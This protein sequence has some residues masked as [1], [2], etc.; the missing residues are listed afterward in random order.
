VKHLPRSDALASASTA[1]EI[2]NAPRLREVVSTKKISEVYTEEGYEDS[3]YDHGGFAKEAENQEGYDHHEGSKHKRK[4][5]KD[6]NVADDSESQGTQTQVKKVDTKGEQLKKQDSPHPPNTWTRHKVVRNETRLVFVENQAGNSVPTKLMASYSHTIQH[7]ETETVYTNKDPITKT[8]VPH[9]D[10]VK[11]TTNSWKPDQEVLPA[12]INPQVHK[13][14]N[15][16]SE[17]K[18]KQQQIIPFFL[19][20]TET[21]NDQDASLSSYTQ[22]REKLYGT[23]INNFYPFATDVNFKE[24]HAN[25]PVE[26]RD[27]MEHINDMAGEVSLNAPN[28]QRYKSSSASVKHTEPE[29]ENVGTGFVAQSTGGS[30]FIRAHIAPLDSIYQ[31]KHPTIPLEEIQNAQQKNVPANAD[32]IDITK[33]FEQD[34]ISTTPNRK[35]HSS[36]LQNGRYILQPLLQERN[37][38]FPSVA[39][40]LGSNKTKQAHRYTSK[41]KDISKLRTPYE[42]LQPATKVSSENSSSYREDEGS[43]DRK[44][45]ENS[46][47]GV[48]LFP[49]VDDPL[50]LWAKFI[51]ALTLAQHSKKDKSFQSPGQGVQL[52]GAATPT[53]SE[54]SFTHKPVLTKHTITGHIN[55]QG[56]DIDFDYHSPLLSRNKGKEGDSTSIT[57]SN[58]SQSELHHF[59]SASRNPT[60][61]HTSTRPTEVVGDLVAVQSLSSEAQTSNTSSLTDLNTGQSKHEYQQLAPDGS[62]NSESGQVSAARR[63]GN[64]GY[65]TPEYLSGDEEEI[66]LQQEEKLLDDEKDKELQKN[67]H[68]WKA[69]LKDA[70]KGIIRK[71]Q[72]NTKKYPFYKA[73]PSNTLS[74][75]SPLRYALNPRAIPSKTEGGMEFYESREHIHCPEVTGPQD[76]V[77][78]RTA[79]GEWN[80]KPKARLPRLRGLGD[81]IDCFRIKYFGFDPLDNPFFKEKTVGLPLVASSDTAESLVDADALGFYSDIMEHIRNIGDVSN[82]PLY[83]KPK[84]QYVKFKTTPEKPAKPSSEPETDSNGTGNLPSVSSAGQYNAE[85]ASSFNSD[86]NSVDSNDTPGYR[87]SIEN[88]VT[89]TPKSNKHSTDVYLSPAVYKHKNVTP[90]TFK[91]STDASTRKPH[92]QEE[93]SVPFP[94]VAQDPYSYA[95][96]E[97]GNYVP[98]AY[99]NIDTPPLQ[100]VILGMVPPP[101]PTPAYLII[102]AVTHTPTAH[103]T[104]ILSVLTESAVTSGPSKKPMRLYNYRNIQGLIP[105]SVQFQRKEPIHNVHNLENE[106]VTANTLSGGQNGEHSKYG[107]I[108]ENSNNLEADPNADIMVAEESS[109]PEI[110][111][112]FKDRAEKVI[113]TANRIHRRQRRTAEQFDRRHYDEIDNDD[114][115]TIEISRSQQQRLNKKRRKDG[116]K[117]K[118][119]SSSARK[120]PGRGRNSLDKPRRRVDHEDELEYQY[121]DDDV[122]YNKKGSK[123]RKA[124]HRKQDTE[125]SDD[126]MPQHSDYESTARYDVRRESDEAVSQTAS[127]PAIE[128][129]PRTTSGRKSQPKSKDRIAGSDSRRGE[130][131]YYDVEEKR[132][133]EGRT[134]SRNRSDTKRGGSVSK[135]NNHSS[136]K[137]GDSQRSARTKL[138]KEAEIKPENSTNT[139]FSCKD[140]EVEGG[141]EDYHS[142]PVRTPPDEYYDDDDDHDG[143]NDDHLSQAEDSVKE[144]E[145][146]RQKYSTKINSKG[147]KRAEEKDKGT[148]VTSGQT[149]KSDDAANKLKSKY[150]ENV[151]SADQI[152]RILGGFMSRHN[153]SYSSK[154][155]A[156]ET[157]MSPE[158][159]E[160]TDP[161]TGAPSTTT[162]TSSTSPT[163]NRTNPEVSKISHTSGG[164][165]SLQKAR[166]IPILNSKVIPELVTSTTKSSDNNTN[167]RRASKNKSTEKPQPS[168]KLPK[169]NRGKPLRSKQETRVEDNH[170][171]LD[172]ENA[173]KEEPPEYLPTRNVPST[174]RDKTNVSRRRN[175]GSRVNVRKQSPQSDV[176]TVTTDNTS[177]IRKRIPIKIKGTERDKQSV[178]KDTEITSKRWRLN[179]KGRENVLREVHSSS[180]S[181]QEENNNGTEPVTGNLSE[182]STTP[183]PRRLQA[184]EHRRVTKEEIF[185]TTYYPEDELAEE[186]ERESEIDAA[187][188][189]DADESQDKIIRDN[190]EEKDEEEDVYEPFESYNYE[191][192]HVKY[193]GNRLLQE[194][195][196]YPEENWNSKRGYFIFHEADNPSYN[197]YRPQAK[198]KE[199]KEKQRFENKYHDYGRAGYRENKP[200]SP[201]TDSSQYSVPDTDSDGPSKRFQNTKDQTKVVTESGVKGFYIQRPLDTTTKSPSPNRSKGESREKAGAKVLTYVVDQNTG[202]GAWIPGGHEGTDVAKRNDKREGNDGEKVELEEPTWVSTRGVSKS[203]N[204]W[205]K[206][207]GEEKDLTQDGEYQEQNPEDVETTDVRDEQ[208]DANDRDRDLHDKS[209]KNRSKPQKKKYSRGHEGEDYTV[210]ASRDDDSGDRSFKHTNKKEVSQNRLRK[211]SG[212]FRQK[213]NTESVEHLPDETSDLNR[214]GDKEKTENSE[215]TVRRKSGGRREF[216]TDEDG[217]EKESDTYKLER[218]PKSGKSAH[219][220]N[221]S[222]RYKGHTNQFKDVDTKINPSASE[223]RYYEE[224]PEATTHNKQQNGEYKQEPSDEEGQDGEEYHGDATAD[225]FGEILTQMPPKHREHSEDFNGGVDRVQRFVKHPGKRYYYY[226]EEPEEAEGKE[227]KGVQ[228]DRTAKSY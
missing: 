154:Y 209:K 112:D 63:K 8:V 166:V 226:V 122:I 56:R 92:R 99:G 16:K 106:L 205:R 76:V 7:P 46:S 161:T 147:F 183:A 82:M 142:D 77:P 120:Q 87:P 129:V 101:A 15:D 207:S 138:L 62:L 41:Y 49:I 12:N 173:R 135:E 123:L 42:Q 21:E 143:D 113:A 170:E 153:P 168:S 211:S 79:P 186:M 89:Q 177:V 111:S 152:N 58:T 193:P 114:H 93:A 97:S 204:N 201:A 45:Q 140:T 132:K 121:D 86:Q 199:N 134:S 18:E 84:T 35:E 39:I 17:N 158:T 119:K 159:T 68:E 5:R 94:G 184:I 222:R 155:K 224:F 47:S 9:T 145:V 22:L 165:K 59:T 69:A 213:D 130:P 74:L 33:P 32:D 172:E 60:I 188:L 71:P 27:K 72:I 169:A 228:M 10:T 117:E 137:K 29:N 37:D 13:L 219:R 25:L 20:S 203:R 36:E 53:H 90:D 208:F 2:A 1:E 67:V 52:G 34:N 31:R 174:P 24:K 218:A 191:S 167:R 178:N 95:Q 185:T 102:R 179:R 38:E 96:P 202:A 198:Y 30:D 223:V 55:G 108:N 83:S 107:S 210:D 136:L 151:M 127:Y 23:S 61:I 118:R 116:A 220:R 105:P 192:R 225:D 162:S 187:E 148:D 73:L 26:E 212:K 131:R 196:P 128:E 197:Y 163:T 109:K 194:Q 51:E 180:N 200:S 98:G 171:V 81:K 217:N 28:T 110:V 100:E 40:L 43:G 4:S 216:I 139:K 164:N 221:K 214:R 78:K 149:S 175:T 146:A 48:A 57:S 19:L 85:T 3:A 157:T 227:S 190:Y 103:P 176:T 181:S 91:Y 126:G 65:G 125:E 189:E 64:D 124:N 54:E 66:R 160:T 75:Y 104:S 156:E 150:P 80:K 88:E 44:S 6:Q 70:E 133:G 115:S 50:P 206:T 141:C 182:N 11:D 215:K 195:N 144:E 14:A